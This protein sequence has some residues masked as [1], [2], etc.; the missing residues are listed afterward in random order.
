MRNADIRLPVSCRADAPASEEELRLR[1]SLSPPEAGASDSTDV[2]PKE[3]AGLNQ[4]VAICLMVLWYFFSA[5]NLFANKYIISF[6]NGEP[7]LLG[8]CRLDEPIFVSPTFVD[9]ILLI[10]NR[11]AMGQML[12]CVIWGFFQLRFPCGL[13]T[14]RPVS[15]FWSSGSKLKMFQPSM[16][17][18]GTLRFTTLVLGLVT[19][20]YVPVSFTETV[21]SSA[22]LFT[23][24]IARILMGEKTGPYVYMSLL[25]IMGGLALC[26][27][28]E[29]SFNVKGFTAALCTNLS[30]W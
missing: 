29:L 21:K 19:L 1:V 12:M 30:E 6:L 26:S 25:P 13:F 24:I 11:P 10:F 14:A 27:A 18:L 23:V 20:N 22:P 8:E 9:V 5:L 16:L 28:T 4:P 17:G 3:K 7:A 2:V 15:A